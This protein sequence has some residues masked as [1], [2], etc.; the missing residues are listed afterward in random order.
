[1]FLKGLSWKFWLSAVFAAAVAAFLFGCNIGSERA[2]TRC[3]TEK[4]ALT[5]QLTGQSL[6]AQ[7]TTERTD[8]AYQAGLAARDRDLADAMREQSCL[9][10]TDHPASLGQPDA[11]HQPKQPRQG[12][13]VNSATLTRFAG[14]CETDRLKVI[15]LQQSIRDIYKALGQ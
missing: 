5:A 7:L 4:K 11:A 9:L 15:G 6:A 13:A 14:Q 12:N 8:N 1:M 10:I 2:A 3:E